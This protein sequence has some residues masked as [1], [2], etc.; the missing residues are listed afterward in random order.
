MIFTLSFVDHFVSVQIRLK[1]K[2]LPT[3]VYDI[4]SSCQLPIQEELEQFIKK[5]SEKRD[6]N[7]QRNIKWSSSLRDIMDEDIFFEEETAPGETLH[8]WLVRNSETAKFRLREILPTADENRR[9]SRRMIRRHHLASFVAEDFWYSQTTLNGAL[10]Q[11]EYLFRRR[12]V[13]SI[14]LYGRTL[15]LGLFNGLDHLGRFIVDISDVPA[16]WI[17]VDYLIPF[18]T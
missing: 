7:K 17:Q 11:M 9:I 14:G 3:L 5:Q 12:N 2:D 8:S 10:K 1:S 13:N 15:K 4:L 6:E 16:A 18:T